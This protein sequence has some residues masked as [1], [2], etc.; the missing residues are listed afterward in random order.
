MKTDMK[1]CGYSHA[2][3]VAIK[4]FLKKKGIDYV[5]TSAPVYDVATGL[6]LVREACFASERDRFRNPFN[7][8]IQRQLVWT[9][10]SWSHAVFSRGCLFTDCCRVEVAA[11]RFRT[12]RCESRGLWLTHHVRYW[13]I[14]KPESHAPS[15][16]QS[17]VLTPTRTGTSQG[18][19]HLSA[20]LLQVLRARRIV[21]PELLL[22]ILHVRQR[23]VHC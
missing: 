7:S 6:P 11:D 1:L 12:D 15:P 21:E 14:T 3:S 23:P 5:P 2:E 13:S 9:M 10:L 16:C 19:H 20:R 8:G 17:R 18:G 4:N 22:Q